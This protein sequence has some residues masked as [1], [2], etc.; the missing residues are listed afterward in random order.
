MQAGLRRTGRLLEAAARRD[1]ATALRRWWSTKNA[2]GAGM[3][4]HFEAS[5]GSQASPALLHALLADATRASSYPSESSV[6]S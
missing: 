5:L 1:R 4:Q 3:G 2:G 6:R